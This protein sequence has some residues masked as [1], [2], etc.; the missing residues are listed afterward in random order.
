M[1]RFSAA[2]L[3]LTVL[4]RAS[5][6]APRRNAVGGNG[7]ARGPR[8]RDSGARRASKLRQRQ[9]GLL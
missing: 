9:D 1:E 3:P 5:V 2:R 4:H 7:V 6:P 8:D